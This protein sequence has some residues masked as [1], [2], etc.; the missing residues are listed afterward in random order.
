MTVLNKKSND[1]LRNLKNVFQA[2]VAQ[3][4]DK[5]PIKQSKHSLKESDNKEKIYSFFTHLKDIQMMAKE[6]LHPS[7][8]NSFLTFVNKQSKF[9]NKND[10]LNHKYRYLTGVS[11]Y[12][13][14]IPN[15]RREIE[16][17]I[18][19]IQIHSREVALFLK[20]KND[21]EVL[22]L[23]GEY[24]RALNTIEKFDNIYG[25]S[26]WSI[27]LKIALH[28]QHLG[29]DAQKKYSAEL[30]QIYKS[31]FLNFVSF[32]TSRINE[33]QTSYT[34]YV[35]TMKKRIK[36]HKYYNHL[37]MNYMTYRMLSIWPDNIEE[38]VDIISIEQNHSV[39]DLYET[40]INFSHQIIK[41]NTDDNLHFIS[42]IILLGR[43]FTDFRIEKLKFYVED[44]SIIKKNYSR[45]NEIS[46]N[47]FNRNY[48]KASAIF[49]KYLLN[50]EPIDIWNYIYGSLSKH[51]V[52][53]IK[54]ETRKVDSFYCH[55]PLIFER[56][57][58]SFS[59]NN[60]LRRIFLCFKNLPIFQG[61]NDFL[62]IINKVY[63]DDIW[64]PWWI[65]LNSNTLG[66]EDIKPSF[67]D[68]NHLENLIY[69]DT[70]K[71]ITYNAWKWLHADY[72][73][74]YSH[75]SEY[76]F[77]AIRHINQKKYLEAENILIIESESTIFTIIKKYL[78]MNCYYSSVKTSDLIKFIAFES[79]KENSH[80]DLMPIAKTVVN[81]YL[82]DYRLVQDP[83]IRIIGMYAAWRVS[84]Y[85][86]EA[87]SSW[88]SNSIR[89]FLHDN[90]L[91][92]PSELGNVLHKYNIKHMI[93][94]LDYICIPQFYDTYLPNVIITPEQSRL[95]R[96]AICNLLIKI[97]PQ[98]KEIYKEEINAINKL[99]LIDEG[100][101]LIARSRIYVDEINLKNWVL[102][103]LTSEIYRYNSLVELKS[104]SKDKTFNALIKELFADKSDGED[105]TYI[106]TES[107]MV[108]LEIWEK[109]EKEFLS[110]PRFGLDFYVSQRI[111]HQSFVGFVRGKLELENIITTKPDE[112]SPYNQNNY[113]LEKFDNLDQKSYRRLNELFI[114]FAKDFDDALFNVKN[115]KFHVKTLNKPN[116]LLYI[117]FTGN[118]LEL[119]SYIIQDA[120]DLNDTIDS[121]ITYLWAAITPQLHKAQDYIRLDLQQELR[122]ICEK[123][124]D[125]VR[126]L[127]GNHHTFCIFA[128]KLDSCM[129]NISSSL[130][131]VTIWFSENLFTRLLD[132]IS[133]EKIIQISLNGITRTFPTFQPKIRSEIK[134]GSLEKIY[135]NTIYDFIFIIF[136][137]IF[138]HSGTL[139]PEIELHASLESHEKYDL[140][141]I[142]V[143]SPSLKNKQTS[144]ELK[145]EERR[146]RI[147][148]RDFGKFT[149]LE[150]GSGLLKV[151]SILDISLT[152]G[153]IE[154]G[155]ND[156]NKFQIEIEASF[157]K[158]NEV[159]K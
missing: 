39:F 26:M 57:E 156:A 5:S 51:K 126:N 1:D 15:I 107:D 22:C 29:L 13:T 25:A 50:K 6:S 49:E 11:T 27:Q 40:L 117:D 86:P 44:N 128:N 4:N 116:G 115:E 96:V 83:L 137:N 23:Q 136:G 119:L 143:I 61:L 145:L 122:L 101:L 87:I 28:Q 52:D 111:R 68:I 42:R 34:H 141:S 71:D 158:Y 155:F 84:P 55:I 103:E 81:I 118:Q 24:A 110:N 64:Q 131:E 151:A 76:I 104:N 75:P 30:R 8:F 66:I 148:K 46:N 88:I 129:R 91:K 41:M 121:L 77:T 67:I 142:K 132:P 157:L 48:E 93:F 109:I 147:F 85:R 95:E 78:L 153:S 9:I 113:W 100:D 12:Q 120:Q 43:I 98:D 144:H 112:H 146:Q 58:I 45:S 80:F 133:L 89:K 10:Q 62:K 152:S 19:R 65:G 139:T 125:S 135:L 72:P 53:S 127:V 16:F 154:F 74:K 35:D 79:L 7:N 99:I 54:F 21:V 69:L 70:H 124:K 94:F 114:N 37:E 159:N 130:E 20:M 90:H 17:A 63:P 47:Y 106:R 33:E 56:L 60:E 92:K 105:L 14:D 138:K 38:Y 2:Y 134:G 97:N 59:A 18:A 31:G 3:L 149:I 123:F 102:K 140:L 73:D 150:G 108:L 82:S 36:S 32:Y